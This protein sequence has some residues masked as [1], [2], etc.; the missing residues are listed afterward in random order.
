MDG[1]AVFF[2]FDSIPL[3]NH[4]AVSSCKCFGKLFYLQ[5]KCVGDAFGVVKLINGVL[6]A[7]G[8]VFLQQ[9]CKLSADFVLLDVITY[10]YHYEM[11][12]CG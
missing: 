5:K 1:I 11:L 10:N 7:N 4:Y 2:Q 9:L 8:S 3:Q 12:N 6:E